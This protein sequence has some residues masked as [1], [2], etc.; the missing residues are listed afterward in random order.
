MIDADPTAHVALHDLLDEP[1]ADAALTARERE[2][3]TL[4]RAVVARE[5][6]PHSARVDLTHEFPH[7]GVQAL[8]REG[9]GGLV[10]PRHL[11][12]SADSNVA[13]ALAMEEIAAGCAATSLVFMTQMHAAY[14]IVLAGSPELQRRF[15]PGLLDGSAY[16]AL[17]ITEPDAGSDVAG[18]TTTAR[19]VGDDWSIT[20][21]KTFITTGDRADVIV[22][23][24]TVDRE[25]GREGI[26]A[27]VVEGDRPGVGRGRPFA[28]LGM[29][30]SSTAELFFDDV[31]VPAANL[32]GAEGE[33]WSVVMSSV[34]KTRISAAAQGVGL[35]RA[36]YAA[37]LTA[38]RRLHGPR[39]PD[40][41]AFALA[42]LRGR[43]LQGRLLLHATAR[44]VDA[45][46][47]TSP[48]Q[49]GIM[50]QVC[51]DLGWQAAV[52]ATRILGPFGDL[53]EIGVERCLRDA[54]VTQ[55][56]DGT[57]EIQRL[58]IGRE[59]TG[60]LRKGNQ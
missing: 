24:A 44:R 26:T 48:G 52:E 23:F 15:V 46:P 30:G 21:Q 1:A 41:L 6:A 3:R 2:I 25:R 22:C 32:L 45:D 39:L 34:G 8:C 35:A 11:G 14:P 47:Q 43:I 51:T 4:T 56:Y 50:K 37:T 42:D 19:R 5:I 33:G 31:R 29:H 36:A 54:K 59:T 9:L 57:N 18:L 17:A 49:I 12:G 7:A 40:E 55:I 16:G 10:F 38:L 53:A 58:L 20:G 27:F 28:K 13:Y 60:R